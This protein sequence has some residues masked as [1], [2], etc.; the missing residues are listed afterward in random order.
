MSLQDDYSKLYDVAFDDYVTIAKSAGESKMPDPFDRS[1]WYG[2]IKFQRWL[3]P[4][5]ADNHVAQLTC[6][7]A[8][9]TSFV[10]SRVHIV[11]GQARQASI[12][13]VDKMTIIFGSDIASV[14]GLGSQGKE[15]IFSFM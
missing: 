2:P 12:S 7:N 10:V 5:Q 11:D 14:H 3:R 9:E 1:Q 4:V 13:P 15:S 8:P 6:E